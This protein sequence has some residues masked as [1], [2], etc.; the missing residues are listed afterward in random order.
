MRD[1]GTFVDEALPELDP[2]IAHDTTAYGWR[3]LTEQGEVYE[4]KGSNGHAAEV[5][6][7]ASVSQAP[8]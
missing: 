2:I 8:S 5:P 4:V 7:V 1:L 3:G 6:P